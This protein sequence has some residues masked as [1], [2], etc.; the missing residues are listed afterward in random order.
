MCRLCGYVVRYGEDGCYSGL[1]VC[2]CCSEQ[3]N[4]FTI[5]LFRSKT[6]AGFGM[7]V[8]GGALVTDDSNIART[9]AEIK[10]ALAAPSNLSE[11]REMDGLT[12][13]AR[14]KLWQYAWGAI[15]DSV[16]YERIG[17]D[18]ALHI[19]SQLKE[20]YCGGMDGEFRYSQNVKSLLELVVCIAR[21]RTGFSLPVDGGPFRAYGTSEISILDNGKSG[22]ANK[23]MDKIADSQ[24][25]RGVMS[26]IQAITPVDIV[27]F[28]SLMITIAELTFGRSCVEMSY[29]LTNFETEGKTARSIVLGPVDPKLRGEIGQY[30]ISILCAK[31]QA[32][33]PPEIGDSSVSKLPAVFLEIPS[34]WLG[35]CLEVVVRQFV[36]E[37]CFQPSLKRSRLIGVASASDKSIQYDA[38]SPN[39][40]K[41]PVQR[42]NSFTSNGISGFFSSIGKML[43]STLESEEDDSESDIDV[44]AAKQEQACTTAAVFRNNMPHVPR[45]KNVAL[46]GCTLSVIRENSGLFVDALGYPTSLESCNLATDSNQWKAFKATKIDL[47]ILLLL[48]R[49]GLK[50]ALTTGAPIAR[51]EMPSI[52]APDKKLVQQSAM[53]H[54]QLCIWS[55]VLTTVLCILSPWRELE[56]DANAPYFSQNLDKSSVPSSID[57]P[58]DGIGF[59]GDVI[60]AVGAVVTFLIDSR[61]VNNI[62]R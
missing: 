49:M 32:A 54:K 23:K 29:N 38:V 35:V 43:T 55:H 15:R 16:C 56:L 28:S 11:D 19:C 33:L 53:S 50:P 9:P 8:V 20:L 25:V 30:M 27:A 61:F 10:A 40:K 60:A 62:V 18:L 14:E 39:S 12:E 58:V 42:E 6:R 57:T 2:K 3:T 48:F 24:L 47:K 46:Y 4:L 13:V 51:G 36:N 5:F 37:L 1:Q 52:S 26:L 31:E 21:P 17:S 34:S 59:A 7:R 22:P 41:N 44:D 45:D